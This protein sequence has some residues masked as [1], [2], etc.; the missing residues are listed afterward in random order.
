[1][2]TC[3][4]YI[5]GTLLSSGAVAAIAHGV[6]YNSAQ[7]HQAFYLYDLQWSI[8]LAYLVVIIILSCSL[9]ILSLFLLFSLF[10]PNHSCRIH[11]FL[12]SMTV[13]RIKQLMSF[14]LFLA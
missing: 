10:F 8:L 2:T 6:R 9:I 5:L 4:A 12:P 14:D 13:L 3:L 7:H 1:M 11:G